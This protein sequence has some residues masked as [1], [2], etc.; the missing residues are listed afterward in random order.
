MVR[1]D[2]VKTERMG[3][4][5]YSS[6]QWVGFDDAKMIRQKSEYIMDNGFGGA[7]VWAL[8]LDDFKNRCG[9]EPHPLL[10]TINR[11]LRGY[12]IP[13]PKCE[14]KASPPRNQA[15]PRI[16]QPLSNAISYYPSAN[17]YYPYVKQPL[18]YRLPQPYQYYHNIF[19]KK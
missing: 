14:I 8:D 9:C 11:V 6:T 2:K 3:P 7:M 19:Y 12:S 5:A 1:D 13:D 16:S 18:P 10:R 17:V 4:Y 15:T